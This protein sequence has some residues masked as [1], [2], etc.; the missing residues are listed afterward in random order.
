MPQQ[1]RTALEYFVFAAELRRSGLFDEKFYALSGEARAAGVDPAV[2][3]LSVGESRGYAPS[4]FFDPVYYREVNPDIAVL[5]AGVNCLHHYVC[6]GRAEGRRPLPMADRTDLPT[7]RI[8]PNRNTV[9]VIAHEATRTG[10][11]ILTWNIGRTLSAHFNIVVVLVRGGAIE[12][13]FEDFA[14]AVIKPRPEERFDEAEAAYL[15]KRITA[16]Y[17]PLYVVANS[18]ATRAFVPA[19]ARVFV[20]VIALVHE[21]SGQMLPIGVL[22]PVYGWAARVVFATALVADSSR[23]DYPILAARH[24]LLLP[25]GPSM[26]PPEPKGSAGK[27]PSAGPARLRPKELGDGLVVVGMGVVDIRKGV[28]FFIAVA[29]EVRRVA[30]ASSVLFVWV[31]P[32]Y[33]PEEDVLYSV[34]LAEQI[35]RSGVEDH[36]VFVDEVSDLEAIYAQ[37][38]IFLVSSRLD[39]L[40]N[41]AIDA[42]LRGIPA[43]CFQNATGLAEILADDVTTRDLVVP[44]IDIAGAAR[45]ILELAADPARLRRLSAAVK[46]KAQTTFDMDRYVGAIDRL[47]QAAAHDWAEIETDRQTILDEGA[48]NAELYLGPGLV[49]SNESAAL[50][51]YL[52]QWHLMHPKCE[53]IPDFS[54]RRPV[55]GFHPLAYACECPDYDKEQREDPLAHFLRAGRPAGRWTHT[56]IVP[57]QRVKRKETDLPARV[58]LHGHFYYPEL[59][60]DLLR[61]L[62]F[63]RFR[64]DLFLTT[65]APAKSKALQDATR[66]YRQG[67]VHLD[68]VPNRGRDIGPFLTLMG[69]RLRQ[70]DVVGHVHGKRT[71]TYAD[72]EMG[73][74]WRDFLLQHLL[75]TKFPMAEIILEQFAREPSLGIVFPEDPHLVGW[76]SNRAEAEKL[77][78][79]MG[80]EGQ[81]PVHFNFPVGT[82]FWARPQAL[83]PLFDLQLWWQDYPEEPV[84]RDGTML[85]ALERLLPFV[86]RS[87]GYDYATTHISGVIR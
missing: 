57:T 12:E 21:F 64:C 42:M 1:L 28:D 73:E 27:L 74:R 58:A 75:G 47:G 7:D 68:L 78:A 33:K 4:Q 14:A 26:L 62:A 56:V 63:N 6:F 60:P 53:T 46:A 37:S 77:A 13:A 79:R 45:L 9:V 31:G 24:V 55:V 10:A 22:Y 39:S 84:P 11:P 5:G 69:D 40:P 16:T 29:A 61:R 15:A 50:T 32:G 71:V 38:D 48:F 3:Y 65:T 59:L 51:D 20:P 83:K 34:Y 36:V 8:D 87:T 49:H 18:V 2:H 44:Y 70:Y 67:A 72:S 85:H 76:D 17:R 52:L 43:I 23:E 86:A 54:L 30:P 25:Q 81:L 82:M 19:F 41:V 66:N 80:L 35:K